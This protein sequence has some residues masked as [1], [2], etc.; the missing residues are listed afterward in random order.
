ML[1]EAGADAN[2]RDKG[3]STPLHDAALLNENPAVVK[4]LLEAG[5]DAN[6][7]AGSDRT[8][9]HHAAGHNVI[10]VVELLLEAG[11]NAN[12]RDDLGRTP[13]HGASFSNKNP[14]FVELLLEAG[15]NANARNKRGNTPLHQAAISSKIPAVV[16]LLLK[17]GADANARNNDG[18]TTLDLSMME[19]DNPE[20]ARVLIDAGATRSTRAREPAPDSKQGTD[21]TKVAVGV[22]GAAAI[23]QAGKDAPQEAVDQAITDWARVMAGVESS[24]DA[25]TAS[26]GPTQTQG[27]QSQA[28][29][30][31][32]P[33]QQ[34]LLNMEAVCREKFRSGFAGNDH[35]RFYC[36]AAFGDACALKRTPDEE[37]RTKLRASLARNC[38]VLQD[39]GAVGKCTYCR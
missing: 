10:A 1:L 4:L 15:A 3:G 27:G 34:A 11:A 19:N 32:D 29:T 8:P 33:M 22:L 25:P 26:G 16:E 5:A 17:A 12:A 31:A 21:W 23:A 13:L 38:G 35:A 18:F 39:I 6:A 30:A 36:L 24:A 9:L 14:A 28:A 7:R 37:A 20:V 2:A